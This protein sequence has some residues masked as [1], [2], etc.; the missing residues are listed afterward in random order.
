MRIAQLRFRY[1]FLRTL[2]PFEILASW[3]PSQVYRATG[4][5]LV[6][7]APSCPLYVLSLLCVPASPGVRCLFTGMATAMADQR[8]FS[9]PSVVSPT[10]SPISG[11]TCSFA[12]V[13]TTRPALFRELYCATSTRLASR[14]VA[15][16]AAAESTERERSASLS[17]SFQASPSAVCRWVMRRSSGST[18]PR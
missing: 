14:E 10:V 1:S 16:W 7:A 18:C 6:R 12:S 8:R 3:S 13:P 4:S 17:L 9:P 2:N 15:L 11:Y 5:V